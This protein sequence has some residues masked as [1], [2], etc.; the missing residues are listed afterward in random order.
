LDVANSHCGFLSSA[1]ALGRL[2]SVTTSADDDDDIV[3]IR[4]HFTSYLGKLFV[5]LT[6]KREEEEMTILNSR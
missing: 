6:E 2:H 3:Q 1:G 4:N 5:V